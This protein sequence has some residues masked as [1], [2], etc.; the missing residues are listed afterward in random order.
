[1]KKALS[2]LLAG[3]MV[4]SLAACGGSKDT[5]TTTDSSSASS[6]A[7]GSDTFK[8]GGTGPITG[9]AA[10]YG[11]AVKNGIQIAVDEINAAG[12]I[13]GYQIDYNFQDDE[14]DAEKAV[15][16][17]NNLKDWGMQVL[18][19]TTTSAPCIAVVE[20]THEDNMF[21][22]TPS[23]TAVECVQYDNAYRMC[24]SDPT[25]GTE[26]AKYIG[27]NGMA[28]KVAVIYD[29][30][31][32]YSTGIY[33]AFAEE[34]ANQPFEIV[35]VEAFTADNK[36]DFSVQVQKSK[37]AGADLLF[38]PFYYTEAS[39][40]LAECNKQGYEPTF[41][42]CDGMDGILGV[43]N[44]DTAL[45]EGLTFLAPFVAK[46]EDEQVQSFVSKY[47]EAYGE[48]PNQFAADAYDCVYVVKAAIEAAGATPDMSV[49]DLCD[50]MKAAM[51][52]VS[53]S[54]ITGKDIT[55]G[56]DGEPNKA[57]L[58]VK[59]VDGEYTEL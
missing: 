23:G 14:H 40:V 55:W 22:I 6:D 26:S 48:T 29:S 13:N 20:K 39:L 36:T 57:P 9:G 27:E 52:D 1:M 12:G 53:Y 34:A 21:Q 35:S 10:I 24:F 32:V 16:A 7:A 5:T 17:Y 44:F 28:Q 2:L 47:E 38:M 46:S 45:A 31:D 18:I 11:N 4:L 30:S 37:D 41:F 8:I 59:V 33:E 50:A 49:S 51:A 43:E 42:G 58:V 19:G 56:E 3:S 15:N 25:Q 54:G